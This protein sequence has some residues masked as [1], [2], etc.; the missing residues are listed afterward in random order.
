[1]AAVTWKN[2]A[3]SNPSGILNAANQAAQGMSEGLGTIGENIN[4]FATD[5][6]TSET[7]A[8]VA[9]LMAAGSQEERDAMIGAANQSWLNLDQVNKTNYE[10][11]APDREMD[12]FNQKLAAEAVVNEE[13][14]QKLHDNKILQIEAEGQ[15][16]SSRNNGTPKNGPGSSGWGK[17]PIG[18]KGI[19]ST[20][21]PTNDNFTGRGGG[22]DADDD[23]HFVRE[24]GNFLNSSY[25]TD[26]SNTLGI[27]DMDGYFNQL[28]NDELITFEDRFTG[29]PGFLGGGGDMFVFTTKDGIKHE[30][31]GSKESQA[32]I[33]ELIMNTY[34]KASDGGMMLSPR[35]I[36]KKTYYDAFTNNNPNLVEKVGYSGAQDIFTKIY[37]KNIKF[38]SNRLSA[39]AT[40]KIFK[41]LT[42]TETSSSMN[43]GDKYSAEVF[44]QAKPQAERLAK[45]MSQEELENFVKEMV[46]FGDSKSDFNWA[47]TDHLQSILNKNAK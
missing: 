19:F 16:R 44:D 37:N 45:E 32:A 23:A 3:P 30:L 29:L 18:S 10:L 47:L 39:E 6:E 9:D 12:M 22:Y 38:N 42:D 7:N 1:M 27:R 8:F 26:L 34:F 40:N 36:D 14:A 24:R 13:T 21:Y 2:I 31:D 20:N 4:Q 11:G 28:A 25:A 33:S 41:T 15:Y 5:K 35:Q 43:I 17:T 46:E